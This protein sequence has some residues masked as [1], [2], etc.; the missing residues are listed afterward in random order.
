MQIIGGGQS[1]R[2]MTEV[3]ELA[4]PKDEYGKQRSAGMWYARPG[5]S[6]TRLTGSPDTDARDDVKILSFR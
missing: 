5:T 3:P 1:R 4:N 6:H 2:V